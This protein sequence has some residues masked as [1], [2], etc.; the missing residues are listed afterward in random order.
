VVALAVA[1]TAGVALAGDVGEGHSKGGSVAATTDA[2]ATPTVPNEGGGATGSA[3]APSPPPTLPPT[4]PE[5]YQGFRLP[6]GYALSWQ[7]SPPVA[8]PGTYSG[9]FG[10][11]PQADAFA[12]DTNQGTLA[13]IA[14]QGSGTLEECRAGGLQTASIPRRLVIAGS[15]V[16]VRSADGTTALLTFRQLTAPGAPQ[17]YAVVDVTVWRVTDTAESDQLTTESL[18]RASNSAEFSPSL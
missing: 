8:R 4:T 14:P 6:A 3:E 11:T 16:C 10:Y 17:P 9:D 18:H 1:V 15:R 12:T 2:K 13:L 5:V 7:A